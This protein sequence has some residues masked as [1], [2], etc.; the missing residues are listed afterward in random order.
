MISR[1]L[2][3]HV[4]HLANVVSPLYVYC[5][6]QQNILEGKDCTFSAYMWALILVMVR[7]PVSNPVTDFGSHKIVLVLNLYANS[8]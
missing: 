4:Y 1:E 3:I 5:H 8:K 6:Q 2:T 7:I